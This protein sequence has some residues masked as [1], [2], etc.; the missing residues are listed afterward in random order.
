MAVYEW[1][2]SRCV[3]QMN[4]STNSSDE[5]KHL[6]DVITDDEELEV[7]DLPRQG[8]PKDVLNVSKASAR[9]PE[10]LIDD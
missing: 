5:P 6:P 7:V 1:A 3:K 4:P 10:L 9:L 2:I 8:I